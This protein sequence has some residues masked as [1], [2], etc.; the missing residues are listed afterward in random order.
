MESSLRK[1]HTKTPH[2]ATDMLTLGRRDGPDLVQLIFGYS[3]R[4]GSGLTT[5]QKLAWR[6]YLA[7]VI[8]KS[9]L[10]KGIA[11]Q[12]VLQAYYEVFD[13][14][15][16]MGALS[17]YSY[18]KVYENPHPIHRRRPSDTQ[19]TMR[20][21]KVHSEQQYFVEIGVINIYHPTAS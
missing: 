12:Q 15:F 8:F 10:G 5:R 4:R 18:I 1:T 20:S 2:L 14:L 17:Q 16:F 7:D 6:K 13:D 3:R 19:T 9:T 11:E 21:R